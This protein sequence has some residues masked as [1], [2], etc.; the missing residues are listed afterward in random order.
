MKFESDGV[1]GRVFASRIGRGT[2]L[3]FM[4]LYVKGGKILVR[5]RIKFF[6]AE[7]EAAKGF[8]IFVFDWCERIGIGD[9]GS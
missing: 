8:I 7:F 9:S 2:G 6:E 1:R 3:F 5:R 4:E